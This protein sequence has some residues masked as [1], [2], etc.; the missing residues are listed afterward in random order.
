MIKDRIENARVYYGI[1][2]RLQK[3]FEWIKNNDLAS[4][5][6]GK[7]EIEGNEIF[8]NLQSYETK[9]TAPFEGHRQYI[10]IQYMVKSE[11]FIGLVNYNECET[12][13]EYNQEKD[14]EFLATKLDNSP[15]ILKEGE[16]FVFFPQ[17][18]HQ[19]ALNPNKKLFVKKVIVKVQ[20]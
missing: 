12:I 5:P 4:M 7:Y 2:E 19:P 16:F 10:D 1:S 9:D 3:G 20:I 8:A 17:D 14:I 6:D 18:A 11:E 15:Q 13:E